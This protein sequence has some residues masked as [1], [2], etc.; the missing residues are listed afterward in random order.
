MAPGDDR[1]AQ[2]QS[3]P[4]RG[5]LPTN[6]CRRATKQVEPAQRGVAVQSCRQRARC[7]AA[8]LACS[9]Y[10]ILH[11]KLLR[12]GL[13]L[14][15]AANLAPSRRR[16]S[17]RRLVST[18]RGLECAQHIITAGGQVCAA[19]ASAACLKLLH[20]QN[21]VAHAIEPPGARR[22]PCHHVREIRTLAR[23]RAEKLTE[24]VDRKLEW[25]GA[26]V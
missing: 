8:W 1:Q 3:A 4:P 25:Q 9:P 24:P 13:H 6:P 22:L 15:R 21:V 18:G 16:R 11:G 14:G 12:N 17:G 10:S 19:R 26:W 5:L 23:T 20:T 2:M 7:L